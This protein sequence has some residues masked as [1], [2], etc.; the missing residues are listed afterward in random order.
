MTA[1]QAIRFIDDSEHGYFAEPGTACQTRSFTRE[2]A[3]YALAN[4]SAPLLLQQ[5]D[6]LFSQYEPMD[7][8]Y[9]VLG[10]CVRE[11]H[12][13]RTGR[14][15][16]VGFHQLN[17][18][19]GLASLGESSYHNMAVALIESPVCI[20][21][22]PYRE[23]RLF[24]DIPNFQHQMWVL[25]GL[26]LT[27]SKSHMLMCRHYQGD[28]RLA[29]FLLAQLQHA[30][31]NAQPLS[32]LFLPM[33]RQD[34]ANYLGMAPETLSRLFATFETRG[35]VRSQRRYVEIPDPERLRELLPAFSP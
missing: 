25:M 31:D 3:N 19:A 28:Q 34:I 14:E 13:D 17:D 12:I 5:G 11:T 15:T 16:I 35:L 7:G 33:H 20:V 18:I 30:R 1:A 10:G 21:P 29:A 9:V 24:S 22:C 23:R 6:T 32:P 2:L 27:A 26:Q 8:F 4:L